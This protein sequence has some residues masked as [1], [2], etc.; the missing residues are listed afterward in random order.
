MMSK[1]MGICPYC[2]QGVMIEAAADITEEGMHSAA[3]LACGCYEAREYQRKVERLEN[4]RAMIAAMFPAEEEALAN[5]VRNVVEV[6]IENQL[7]GATISVGY[8]RSIK[9]KQSKDKVQI[10]ETRRATAMQ[11]V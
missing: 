4:A 7:E 2:G 8:G 5:I 6:I 1:Q 10:V 3:A 11:E 9:I